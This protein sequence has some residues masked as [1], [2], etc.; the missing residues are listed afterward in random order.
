MKVLVC[1]LLLPYIC[2]FWFLHFPPLFFF[3]F[4]RKFHYNSLPPILWISSC[5]WHHIYL[6][7]RKRIN[8]TQM[9][10]YSSIQL[11]MWNSTN[12]IFAV[13]KNLSNLRLA[14]LNFVMNLGE[15]YTGLLRLVVRGETP[16][17]RHS[18]YLTPFP[19]SENTFH[20]SVW[21]STYL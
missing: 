16:L 10:V 7:F 8:R 5:K 15:H 12:E 3:C 14:F 13:W 19:G 4:E 20:L 6:C 2:I 17:A 9:V 18:L 21:A 11:S 1:V